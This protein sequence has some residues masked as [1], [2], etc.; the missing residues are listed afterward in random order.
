M[1]DTQ[2]HKPWLRFI[3]LLFSLTFVAAACGDDGGSAEGD[4]GGTDE[5]TDEATDSEG[6]ER[7][8]EMGG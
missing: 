1:T 4:D 2:R 6:P 3:A 7:N 8:P 5:A